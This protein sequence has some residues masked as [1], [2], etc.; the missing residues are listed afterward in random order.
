LGFRHL[1]VAR[2][3][4]DPTK[5]RNN[6]DFPPHIR[7]PIPYTPRMSNPNAYDDTTDDMTREE[8]IA[9]L[10]E[11]G[12]T[13]DEATRMIGDY[14]PDEYEA[15]YASDFKEVVNDDW[16]DAIADF[17]DPGDFE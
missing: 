1:I 12:Y 17:V 11:E 5:T 9:E 16:F 6:F 4:S 13:R 7:L 14:D 3:L 8:A 2:T 15:E 10:M